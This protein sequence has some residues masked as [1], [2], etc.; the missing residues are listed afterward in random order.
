MILQA[1]AKINLTLDVVGKRENGYHDVRMI[2]QTVSL[3]DTINIHKNQSGIELKCNLPYVPTDERN[4]AFKAAKLFYEETEIQ[5]GVYIN[6]RKRIPVAA[7]MAGGSTDGAAVLKGLNVIYGKP[8]SQEK[9]EEIAAKLGADVPYCINGRL[10]LAEG[11]GEKLT[12]LPPMP[13]TIV[14][15]AKPDIS[16]STKWVYQNLQWDKVES[17][18]DTDGALADLEKG[19]IKALSGKMYNV[20]EEVSVKRYPVI[21]K[22][23]DIMTEGGAL[24]SMMSGSGP[25]VFGIYDNEDKAKATMKILEKKCSFVYLGHTL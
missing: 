4:I 10:A 19:D 22:L 20:L 16:L 21:Q 23:K 1:P 25:T 6:I 12:H 8:L 9:L 24:K 17:H 14:L 18:P 5:G 2:M 11:I 15:L 13:R 7:G 3:Y